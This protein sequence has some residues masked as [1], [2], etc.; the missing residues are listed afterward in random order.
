[1]L[2]EMLA[3]SP[4]VRRHNQFANVN[5][6]DLFCAKTCALRRQIRAYLFWKAIRHQQGLRAIQRAVLQQSWMCWHMENFQDQ[7]VQPATSATTKI[8]RSH[9]MLQTHVIWALD[10][11]LHKSHQGWKDAEA[12]RSIVWQELSWSIS[13]WRENPNTA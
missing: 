3:L 9:T 8:L 2:S 12:L 5:P 11:R 13:S 6:L 7:S 4:F 1:M 10:H